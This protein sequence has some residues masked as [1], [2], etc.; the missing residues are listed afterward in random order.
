[1]FL[2]KLVP[3]INKKVGARLYYPED[4]PPV[5]CQHDGVCFNTITVTTADG[6]SISGLATQ[7]PLDARCCV[8]FFHGNSGS[9]AQCA[10]LVAPLY[11]LGAQIIVADYRGYGGNEG[12]PSE[13]GLMHDARAFYRHATAVSNLPVLLVGHSLGGNIAIQLTAEGDRNIVGLVT[14]N[15]VASVVAFVPAYI[16][17]FV[18]DRFEA[19]PKARLITIPWTIAHDI[20]DQVVPLTHG[21]ALCH[22]AFQNVNMRLVTLNNRRHDFVVQSIAPLISEHLSILAGGGCA[23]GRCEPLDVFGQ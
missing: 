18:T 6:L 9:A 1:M 19:A 17:R 3:G 11:Q 4:V 13:E 14:V 2:S 23:A 10:P 7:A 5:D 21:L 16:R 22:D 20:G 12:H 15:A 8:V